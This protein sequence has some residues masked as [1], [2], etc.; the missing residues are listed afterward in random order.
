MGG[1]DLVEKLKQKHAG[2]AV[3]FMSG[4]T[5]LAA[6]ENANIGSDSILLNKPFSTETLAH[7]IAEALE[8][9]NGA[10][11]QALAVGSAE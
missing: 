10:G 6:F 7:K 8:K 11:Q 3:I 1:V 4:Y 9:T 2:I 5:E